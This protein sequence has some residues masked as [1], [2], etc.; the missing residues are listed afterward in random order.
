MFERGL[1]KGTINCI[2]VTNTKKATTMIP[3]F[4]Q[5]LYPL[6]KL[7][8]DGKPRTMSD[9]APILAKRM[10]L[11]EADLL[12]TFEKSGQNRHYDR[13][14]WAKTYLIKAG[15]ISSPQKAMFVISDHGRQLLASGETN[16]TS[17]FL[18]EHYPSFAEFANRKN[19]ASCTE[20]D[21]SVDMTPTDRMVAA[22]EELTANIADEI[23]KAVLAQSPQ[24]FEE[25][26]V[27]LL[28]AMGYGGDFEGAAKVTQF[29]ADGG[30]DGIIKEDTLGL[31][32]IYIQ[33]KRW[34]GKTVGAPDIQQFMGALMTVGASKGVYITTSHFSEEAKRAAS[35]GSVKVVLID[36]EQLA[37]YMIKF[38]V[39]VVTSHSFEVKRIDLGFF[40]PE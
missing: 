9:I 3:P 18:A 36:G 33:A 28:V 25:L 31:D 16:I 21:K 39:G 19:S 22:Y 20:A 10:Q 38:N 40:N 14:S 15:L 11:S 12:E 6:L 35:R 1:H 5:Y 27:K 24:F 13:C 37:R 4:Q 23:L 2:F 8:E 17:R 32:K 29:S 34:S 30:I 7:M 26:V